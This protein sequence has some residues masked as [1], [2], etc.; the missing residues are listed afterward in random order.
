M[1]LQGPTAFLYAWICSSSS[2]SY[3]QLCRGFLGSR[4]FAL[5]RGKQGFRAKCCPETHCLG[6]LVL[7][8]QSPFRGRTPPFVCKW[9]V[10]VIDR[11]PGSLQKL[12]SVSPSIGMAFCPYVTL[13]SGYNREQLASTIKL[14]SFKTQMITPCGFEKS[15]FPECLIVNL[16]L[17][18][19]RCGMYGKDRAGVAPESVF[20]DR[21]RKEEP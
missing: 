7:P 1:S 11:G 8:L 13:K 4:R 14:R 12:H 19:F 21:W 17:V 10:T 9:S 2:L 5:G 3:S 20:H 18:C 6:R 15:V 16:S